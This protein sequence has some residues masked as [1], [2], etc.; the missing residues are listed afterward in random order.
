MSAPSTTAVRLAYF[1]MA[2]EP[3][4]SPPTRTPSPRPTRA[5]VDAA[6]SGHGGAR[7]KTTHGRKQYRSPEAEHVIHGRVAVGD[8]LEMRVT[9]T[10]GRLWIRLWR[11]NPNGT[12]WPV[13]GAKGVQVRRAETTAFKEAVRLAC[14]ALGD[15]L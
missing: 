1:G 13:P 15:D 4:A 6:S 14:E 7:P 12:W 5:R 3:E 11:K 10:P 8:G 2:D 9:R